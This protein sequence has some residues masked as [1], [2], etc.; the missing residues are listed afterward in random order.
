MSVLEILVI[1][2]LSTC[3]TYYININLNRGGVIASAIVTLS[4]GIILPYL[5][6]VNGTLFA[7]V[8]T[9]GSYAAMVSID[10]FPKFKDMIFIG[11]FVGIIFI[12][13]QDVF[14]GVGGRLG[15]IAAISGFTWLGIRNLGS[16]LVDKYTI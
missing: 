15:S 2:I 10:I 7:T 16:R 9:S 11:T 13:T 6:P 14:V 1:A 3:F 4:S 12:L 5:F 8:A